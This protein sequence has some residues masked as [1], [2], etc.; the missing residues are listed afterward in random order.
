MALALPKETEIGWMVEWGGW[1][2]FWS[3]FGACVLCQIYFVTYCKITMSTTNDF[4]VGDKVIVDSIS[5]LGVGTVIR[6]KLCGLKGIVVQYGEE[7]GPQYA[8]TSFNGIHI[9][10]DDS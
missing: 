7:E 1:M 2:G 5:H 9:V 4:H 6:T 3:G 8:F 10:E